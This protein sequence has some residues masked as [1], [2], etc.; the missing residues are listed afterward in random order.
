[1]NNQ[2]G[3]VFPMIMIVA[4]VFIMFTILMIDQFIIDKMFYKE[5]EESLVADHLVHLA[6]KDVTS[7]WGE[8]VPEIIQGEIFYPNGTV[9]YSLTEEDGPYVYIE[10]SSSTKNDR[11]G[12]VIIQYDTEA[13]RVIQWIEKQAV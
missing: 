6:V 12:R 9:R 10:F 11:R 8:E 7:E 1:M 13:G 5:V 4:S 3:V 2:K